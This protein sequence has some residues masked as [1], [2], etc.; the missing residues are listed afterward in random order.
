M[1]ALSPDAARTLLGVAPGADAPALRRAYRAAARELHPDVL[2][3]APTPAETRRMAEVNEAYRLLRRG[4]RAA[5]AAAPVAAPVRPVR[6]PDA[7]IDTSDLLYRRP[8]YGPLPLR[9]SAPPPRPPRAARPR[10]PLDVVGTPPPVTVIP[11]S[12]ASPPPDPAA[13]RFAFGRHEGSTVAAVGEFD[14]EY[15][16]WVV[17]NVRG[18]PEVVAAARAWLARR[19][20]R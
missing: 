18:A 1:S 19:A 11:G 9:P 17:G 2:G 15:L 4:L 5:P 16:V 20:G 3:H 10:R 8:A 14:P 7:V 13:V 12:P 6:P